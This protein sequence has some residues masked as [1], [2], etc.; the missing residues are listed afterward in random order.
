MDD[1]PNSF[2][3]EPEAS[4]I[5]GSNTSKTPDQIKITDIAQISCKK[6]RVAVRKRGS[7]E[8][9]HSKILTASPQRRKLQE[10][11]EKQK[12]AEEKKK[13]IQKKAATN[14]FSKKRM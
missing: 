12:K 4:L 6:Y 5:A 9:L 7:R 8:K 10:K 14:K 13:N 3:N 1:L 11:L 2:N